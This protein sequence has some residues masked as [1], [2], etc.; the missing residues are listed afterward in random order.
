MLESYELILIEYQWSEMQSRSSEWH[1]EG[2]DDMTLWSLASC[3]MLFC[4]SD[5]FYRPERVQ[6]QRNHYAELEATKAAAA[7]DNA[8]SLPTPNFGLKITISEKPVNNDHVKYEGCIYTQTNRYYDERDVQRLLTGVQMVGE[9]CARENIRSREG[10][11]RAVF[12]WLC[13]GGIGGGWKIARG[14]AVDAFDA[15]WSRGF[16][17]GSD[18]GDYWGF[19]QSLCN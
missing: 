17:S 8:P 19:E 2:T 16:I 11:Q 12:E 10:V 15:R 4:D 3:A 6:Q 1:A 13:G 9:Q 18:Y 14:V 7:D 5:C